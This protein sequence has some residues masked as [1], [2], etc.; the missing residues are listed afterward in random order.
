MHNAAL[1]A[2]S[3]ENCQRSQVISDAIANLCA[4]HMDSE[5]TYLMSLH[6]RGLAKSVAMCTTAHMFVITFALADKLC[7]HANSQHKA[8]CSC[9]T[10]SLW[11]RNVLGLPNRR[12]AVAS[13]CMLRYS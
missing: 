10:A 3:A 7:V 6:Q 1:S 2:L 13:C 8:R 12:G 11:Q 5:T 4:S 9:G